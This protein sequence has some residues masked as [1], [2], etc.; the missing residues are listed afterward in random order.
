[1]HLSIILALGGYAS[2]L[3]SDSKI[4]RDKGQMS[5]LLR[6]LRDCVCFAL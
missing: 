4:G 2:I 5:D 6:E 1:M 3:Q